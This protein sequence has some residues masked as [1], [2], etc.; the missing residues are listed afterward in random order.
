MYTPYTP[1]YKH[2]RDG[3]PLYCGTNGYATAQAGDGSRLFWDGSLLVLLLFGVG[4]GV[5]HVWVSAATVGRYEEGGEGDQQQKSERNGS[6]EHASN[7]PFR[8]FLFP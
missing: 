4:V 1:P 3:N 2:Y 8:L 6:M 7:L 5:L